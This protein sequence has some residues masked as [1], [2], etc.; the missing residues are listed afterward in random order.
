MPGFWPIPICCVMT[1]CDMESARALYKAFTSWCSL[2]GA[3]SFEVPRCVGGSSHL[4]SSM[5]HWPV[6]HGSSWP[7]PLDIES[8][9]ILQGEHRTSNS[10]FGSGLPPVNFTL[11][12][13]IPFKSV[14]RPQ[15]CILYIYIHK[16]LI[17]AHVPDRHVATWYKLPEV[18]SPFLL[19]KYVESP[20]V[21]D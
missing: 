12:W 15:M 21:R 18:K 9:T 7:K 11:L 4:E 14:G 17:W 20:F 3:F 6:G 10:K 16:W 13:K 5:H 8:K 19:V 2:R 1:W